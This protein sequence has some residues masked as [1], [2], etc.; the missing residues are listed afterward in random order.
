MYSHIVYEAYPHLSPVVSHDFVE[1][2]LH[3]SVPE[4]SHGGK[5]LRATQV[6]EESSIELHYTEL[7]F[8]FSEF[9]G[10]KCVRDVTSQEV[11]RSRW[12]LLR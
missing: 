3:V 1:S 12:D 6:H 2:I 10:T 5:P 8:S 7:L 11:R 9:A 4:Q